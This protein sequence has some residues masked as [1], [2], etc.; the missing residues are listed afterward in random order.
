MK[1]KK[2]KTVITQDDLAIVWGIEDYLLEHRENLLRRLDEGATIEPGIFTLEHALPEL[3]V[4][5]P[6]ASPAR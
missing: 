3:P 1:A 4:Q 5:E 2:R 6:G